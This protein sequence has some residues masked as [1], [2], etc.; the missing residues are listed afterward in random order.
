MT[1]FIGILICA[2]VFYLYTVIAGR[3]L[4]KPY[5]DLY[6]ERERS[7]TGAEGNARGA[8]EEA[9]K[10]EAQYQD[11]FTDAQVE[12][13]R[14]KMD[15]LAQARKEASRIVSTAENDAHAKIVAARAEND[16][17]AEQIRSDLKSDVEKISDEIVS[18]LKKPV[19]IS[20]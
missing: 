12:T 9:A 11:A 13:M 8:L 15:K 17:R 1:D 16:K 10:L 18:R 3:V 6:E 5:L 19:E 20:L 14:V 4:F 2:P 7:T